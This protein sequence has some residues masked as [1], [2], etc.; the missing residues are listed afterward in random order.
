[1]KIFYGDLLNN[2]MRPDVIGAISNGMNINVE[3]AKNNNEN[4]VNLIRRFTKRVQG[5]GVLKRVRSLRYSGRQLSKYTRK[6]K[7]LKRITKTAHVERL[8]KLGRM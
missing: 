5:S 6:K 7:A 1:L 3:V 8:K 2:W 4:A